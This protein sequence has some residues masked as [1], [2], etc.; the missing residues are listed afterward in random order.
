MRHGESTNQ[1]TLVLQI[2][3][4]DCRF[5]GLVE[6]HHQLGLESFVVLFIVSAFLE[7]LLL[8]EILSS[9]IGYSFGLALVSVTR[10]TIFFGEAKFAAALLC[11]SRLRLLGFEMLA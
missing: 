4:D 6:L 11:G 8:H 3:I 7:A 1:R 2:D 9:L 10:W 5:L